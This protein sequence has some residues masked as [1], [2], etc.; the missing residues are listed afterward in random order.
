MRMVAPHFCLARTKVRTFVPDAR[1]L[2]V[3]SRADHPGWSAWGDG[4]GTIAA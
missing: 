4:A 2:E 3:F 1:R